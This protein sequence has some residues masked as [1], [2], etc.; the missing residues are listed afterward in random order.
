MIFFQGSNDSVFKETVESYQN[1]FHTSLK[2]IS[3]EN[4]NMAGL[5]FGK[6]LLCLK[7]TC[8][9]AY[10]ESVE[11]LFFNSMDE[12]RQSVHSLIQII[13]EKDPT[14]LEQGAVFWQFK[15]ESKESNEKE[16]SEE[17]IVIN[18]ENSNN[19]ASLN[20]FIPLQI[21]SYLSAYYNSMQKKNNLDIIAS[22]I[23]NNIA[24]NKHVQA[25]N[26][27]AHCFLNSL[28]NPFLFQAPKQTQSFV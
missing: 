3:A 1:I 5:R 11:D 12:R 17:A 25:N 9:I 20:N 21:P 18:N 8:H 27:F 7:A 26:S 28:R 16:R 24:S 10:K 15:D 4:D 14:N 2:S 19:H 6:T 23:H 13:L 22:N